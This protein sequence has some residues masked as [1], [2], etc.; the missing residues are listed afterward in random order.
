[1]DLS[2]LK[3]IHV[4]AAAVSYALFFLR[5]VWRLSGSPLLQ[6]RWVRIVPHVNDS[7]LLAAAVWMAVILHQYPGTH[8]WLTAKLAGLI[9]YIALGVLA[10]RFAR[11]RRAQ[12]ASWIAAQ[13][14]FAY[15]V[16]VALTHDP[17]PFHAAIR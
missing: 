13:L 12:L 6:R 1:V 3:T 8:A 14:V 17:L 11:T 4:G 2:G 15:I 16:A 9:A 5:G 7:L 10:L